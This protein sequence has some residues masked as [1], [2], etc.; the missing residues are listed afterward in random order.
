MLVW[1]LLVVFILAARAVIGPLTTDKSKKIFLACV[2]T[3]TFLVMGL[4]G[5]NYANVYDLRVYGSFYDTI[6]ETPWAN[7][8]EV[9]DFEVGYVLLNKILSIFFPFTQAIILFEAAFC[10][11]SVC[12][13]IYNNTN[14]V[15]FAFYFYVTLGSMG[16]MLTGFR[17]A[18]AMCVCLFAI[19][20]I[21]KKK[22]IRYILLILIAFS[23]HKSAIVFLPLYF[24][25]AS[26]LIRKRRWL[27]IPIVIV[28]VIFAP[29]ILEFGNLISDGELVSSD[30]AVFSFNGIVP[31]ILFVASLIIQL[32]WEKIR[33][34]ENETS[35]DNSVMAPMIAIGLGFYVMRYYN[36]A[37]ERLAWYYTQAS[38]ICLAG[39]F[40]IWKNDQYKVII[41]IVAIILGFVLFYKRLQT[42]DYAQYSFFWN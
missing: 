30:E 17:Q 2:G 7:I 15:F 10:V 27:I 9:S 38:Y 36:F 8:F 39:F 28:M 18:I 3:A 35:R 37:I 6:I 40:S 42:A 22:L 11:L 5:G 32:I 12:Y 24:I 13:F 25:A 34:E 4:R 1:L 20:A 21:K 31:V 14:N 23:I 29:A 19:E 16:F 33:G 26:K 41:K